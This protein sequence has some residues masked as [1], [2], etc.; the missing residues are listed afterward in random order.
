MV[1][2]GNLQYQDHMPNAANCRVYFNHSTIDK[3]SKIQKQRPEQK[4]IADNRV[5]CH[6]IIVSRL[7]NESAANQ[8]IVRATAKSCYLKWGMKFPEKFQ[9]VKVPELK[10]P[11]LCVA[12][13]QNCKYY[14]SWDQVPR[15]ANIQISTLPDGIKLAQCSKYVNK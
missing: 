12:N 3:M 10:S 15:A 5:L 9:E 6:C 4:P 13:I 8:Q 2:Y 11:R 1:W 14:Q 7:Q